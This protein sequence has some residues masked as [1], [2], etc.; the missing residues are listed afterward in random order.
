[1]LVRIISENIECNLDLVDRSLMVL[2][3]AGQIE[4]VL[5]NLAANAR[6]AMP[7]GGRLTISTELVELDEEYVAVYGCSKPGRYALLTVTDI[8]QGMDAETQKRIFEPF[9]T[10]KGIGEG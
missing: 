10:T 9:F 1:M 2:A 5:I 4:Q 3:D 7:A 6:D 8:G